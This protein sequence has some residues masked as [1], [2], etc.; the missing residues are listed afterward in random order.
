MN[1]GTRDGTGPDARRRMFLAAAGGAGTSLLAGCL[2]G[3]NDDGP[4]DG[5]GSGGSDGPSGDTGWRTAELRTVRGEETFTI[6]GWN[7]RSSP[8]PS[9]CGVRNVGDSPSSSRR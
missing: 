6:G 3:G 8:N 2:G 7:R 4:S 9:R 1:D 5:G